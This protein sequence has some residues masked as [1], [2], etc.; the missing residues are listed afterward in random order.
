M[1]FTAQDKHTMLLKQVRSIATTAGNKQNKDKGVE[2]KITESTDRKNVHFETNI[3][4]QNQG[5]D[6]VLQKVPGAVHKSQEI[7]SPPR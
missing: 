5:A 2:G 6:G 4:E 7:G 3:C 1:R